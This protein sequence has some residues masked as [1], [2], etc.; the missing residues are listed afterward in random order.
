MTGT[1]RALEAS[2]I[3]A[4]L[5]ERER[6]QNTAVGLGVALPHAT[7][8]T[9]DRTYLGVF[10]TAA[11]IDYS[12]PDGEGVDVFFATIGPSSERQT[13]LYLLADVSKLVLK[14]SLLYQLRKAEDT[15]RIVAAIEES[16]R[17]D[18]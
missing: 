17:E 16:L 9:A 12:A 11:P 4:H 5:N 15:D 7:V 3:L 13:H 14:T 1:F 18:S 8:D 6:T 10:T 2:D